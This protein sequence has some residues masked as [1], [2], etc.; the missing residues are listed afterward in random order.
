MGEGNEGTDLQTSLVGVRIGLVFSPVMTEIESDPLA[1]IEAIWD[2]GIRRL[3]WWKMVR[4]YVFGVAYGLS[5]WV[6]FWNCTGDGV[7]WFVFGLTVG[8]FVLIAHAHSVQRHEV[9]RQIGKNLGIEI[10]ADERWPERCQAIRSAQID[11]ELNRTGSQPVQVLAS[12]SDLKEARIEADRNQLT[13]EG[14]IFTIIVSPVGTGIW[15]ALDLFHSALRQKLDYLAVLALVIAGFGLFALPWTVYVLV[16]IIR[17]LQ[18]LYPDRPVDLLVELRRRQAIA[19]I[20]E[21][22]NTPR[23][24]RER[25]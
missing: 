14:V 8:E 4:S 17:S 23:T 7:L 11:E 18:R 5:L 25:L 20:N 21:T 10:G 2:R 19:V 1:R 24:L 22:Q 13:V 3:V 9:Q 16:K 12:L 15:L 6:L